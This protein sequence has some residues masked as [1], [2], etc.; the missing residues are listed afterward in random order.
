M[1]SQPDPPVKMAAMSE[2]DADPVDES[3]HHHSA[4]APQSSMGA[5]SANDGSTTE[6]QGEPVTK[7]VTATQE[8]LEVDNATAASAA[9]APSEPNINDNKPDESSIITDPTIPPKEQAEEPST[10]PQKAAKRHQTPSSTPSTPSRP[11]EA[12]C[13]SH[14]SF[15]VQISTL[16]P[17]EQGEGTVTAL[18]RPRSSSTSSTTSPSVLNTISIN[19]HLPPH[20]PPSS[21]PPFPPV[22]VVYQF[23]GPSPTKL[24]R[25]SS[26]TVDA[27]GPRIKRLNIRGCAHHDRDVDF[28]TGSAPESPI[29]Q[30]RRACIHREPPRS[31]P[32]I[33]YKYKSPPR[34]VRTIAASRN[35]TPSQSTLRERRVARSVPHIHTYTPPPRRISR[36]GFGFPVPV[37]RIG[38]YPVRVP[39]GQPAAR[40]TGVNAGAAAGDDVFAGKAGLRGV[41]G[42]R[43]I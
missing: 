13:H 11:T 14:N 39:A 9:T 3:Q 5:N 26:P 22:H 16:C 25:A 21:T 19:F 4:T 31:E 42:D 30:H 17:G 36:S 15:A 35:G 33:T 28:D 38:R 8:T 29:R 41:G 10:T 18:K 20:H 12:V 37:R 7:V 24:T 6:P 40:Q 32:S 34:P 23:H 27:L 43:W 2:L 1:A